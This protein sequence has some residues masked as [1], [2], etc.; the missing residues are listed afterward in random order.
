[1]H[2]IPP[3]KLTKKCDR[4]Q[5][6]YPKN[7]KDY[8]YCHEENKY[9]GKINLTVLL[10]LELLFQV[11]EA[12]AAISKPNRGFTDCESIHSSSTV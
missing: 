12:L 5:F 9:P 4:C 3:M 6:R 11:G 2:L 10:S 1:M 7:E 8:R